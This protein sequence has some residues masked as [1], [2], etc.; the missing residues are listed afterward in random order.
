MKDFKKPSGAI[1]SVN[2]DC[3]QIAKDL[4]W[5]PVEKAAPK[6]EAPKFEKPSKFK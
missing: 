2:A 4:G 3:E 6:Q 5:T 1:V